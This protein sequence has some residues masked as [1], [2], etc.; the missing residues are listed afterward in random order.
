MYTLGRLCNVHP[1]LLSF[2]VGPQWTCRR[3]TP[4]GK[5]CTNIRA[6][7][8]VFGVLLPLSALIGMGAR[9]LHAVR[10]LHPFFIVVAVLLYYVHSF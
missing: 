9:E 3:R 7:L 6:V 5:P 1:Q 8:L 10:P 4:S 2:G